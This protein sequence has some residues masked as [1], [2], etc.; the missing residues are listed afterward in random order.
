LPEH[1][2]D[3]SP[4]PEDSHRDSGFYRPAILCASGKMLRPIII[5]AL[6]PQVFLP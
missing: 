3:L 2:W 1:C 6:Q 4:A 5:H